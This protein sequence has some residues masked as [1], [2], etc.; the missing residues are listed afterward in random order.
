MLHLC[1]VRHPSNVMTIGLTG[2]IACGKSTFVRALS[3]C[4]GFEHFSADECVHQLLASDPCLIKAV[5]DAFGPEVIDAGGHVNRPALRGIVFVDAV[6]RR[7]LEAIL[8]P[9]VRG[10]WQTQLQNCHASGRH[11]LADI[12]LLFETGSERSFGQIVVV[13]VSTQVQ[14]ARLATRGL[15][16]AIAEAMLASQA[17][18]RQKIDQASIVVWNDG[19]E[20]SLHRQASLAA[21]LLFAT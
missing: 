2:G 17:P 1:G 19:N 6:A 4:H 8:H 21:E 18:I 13:A 14:R 15:Q 3:A 12:P 16:S 7:K 5:S 20:S 11:F 9:V 10:R